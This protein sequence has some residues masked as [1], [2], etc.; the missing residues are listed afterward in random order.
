MA[1]VGAGCVLVGMGCV[2]INGED[3]DGWAYGCSGVAASQGVA[4]R[5]QIL[6]C[7]F[8]FRGLFFLGLPLSNPILRLAL[9]WHVLHCVDVV[10]AECRFWHPPCGARPGAACSQNK[11]GH[12][13]QRQGSSLPVGP[14]PFLNFLHRGQGTALGGI[15]TT[16]LSGCNTFAVPGRQIPVES[17]RT[18]RETSQSHR[19]ILR[20]NGREDAHGCHQDVR[21]AP[22]HRREARA[23]RARPASLVINRVQSTTL[24]ASRCGGQVVQM[25]SWGA[26]ASRPSGEKPI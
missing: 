21:T 2:Q 12:E 26:S 3:G 19:S 18:E 4:E 22:H 9:A 8:L 6:R 20:G 17:A 23:P 16:S 11:P 10:P 13:Q 24:I 7:R 14:L 15:R 25:H 1:R 5:H